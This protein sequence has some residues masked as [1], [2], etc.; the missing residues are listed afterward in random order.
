[1]YS[2]QCTVY[3]VQCTIVHST[4]FINI[5][6]TTEKLSQ[7]T[8]VVVFSTISMANHV[9]YRQ[10]PRHQPCAIYR[11]YLRYTMDMLLALSP[12]KAIPRFVNFYHF[13]LIP[14]T[15]CDSAPFLADQIRPLPVYAARIW[16]T[17]IIY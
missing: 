2:V 12:F 7:N 4:M 5:E 14:M 8:L 6:C 11:F 13:G 9:I 1:M 15:A 10:I 17:P 16:D 3:I